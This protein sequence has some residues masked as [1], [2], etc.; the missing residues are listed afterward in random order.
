MAPMSRARYES[1]REAALRTTIK[2]LKVQLVRND[3]SIDQVTCIA[4]VELAAPAAGSSSPR[5]VD[6]IVVFDSLVDSSSRK[7]AVEVDSADGA[8]PYFP[9]AK[10]DEDAPMQISGIVLRD[11]I[12]LALKSSP[13]STPSAP[14]ANVR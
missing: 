12:D 3:T 2:A 7:I 5:I 14:T 6:T 1:V 8:E 11:W 10:F 13:E 4:E 9:D